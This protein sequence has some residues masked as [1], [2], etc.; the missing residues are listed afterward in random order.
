MKETSLGQSRCV[1]GAASPT[2]ALVE[3][4]SIPCLSLSSG[5]LHSLA[6]ALLSNLFHSN[7]LMFTSG[8]INATQFIFLKKN[9]I[10]M[11]ISNFLTY[12]VF[13]PVLLL[14][15]IF[16]AIWQC[17]Q[18]FPLNKISELILPLSELS[19]FWQMA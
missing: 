3:N 2:E 16:M 6:Q 1:H 4:P 9:S 14:A 10:T 5:C 19:L 13:H 11:R 18:F 7:L 8:F 12:W 15:L 17:N